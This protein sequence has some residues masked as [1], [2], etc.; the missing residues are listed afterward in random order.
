MAPKKK[1]PGLAG[2][3]GHKE[4]TEPPAAAQTRLK[5]T[6]KYYHVTVRLDRER[7]ERAHQVARSEGVPLSQ[8]MI[9]GLSKILEEK[10]LPPL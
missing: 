6:G 10:G 3:F 4:G 5:G 7:W 2:F 1:S 8:M 9:R